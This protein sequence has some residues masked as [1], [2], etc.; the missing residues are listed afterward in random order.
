M[1]SSTL[2]I[3]DK[4]TLVEA[5]FKANGLVRQHLDSFNDFI[6]NKLQEIIDEQGEIETE[7]PGLKVKLG[8]IRIGKPRLMETDRGDREITPMEAR[9][10]NLTYAAP[11]HLTM[12]PVENNIEAN[13]QMFI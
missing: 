7:I 5:Y 13:L 3:D 6:R 11:L 1:S 2:T 9:L 12:I 8:K 10:R 4:W